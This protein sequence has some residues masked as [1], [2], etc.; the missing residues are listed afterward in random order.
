M[1]HVG[2]KTSKRYSP[3]QF[4][5]NLNRFV[6]T[7]LFMWNIAYYFSAICQILKMLRHFAIFRNLLFS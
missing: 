1:N 7:M 3:T 6:I 4:S 2:G 5:F